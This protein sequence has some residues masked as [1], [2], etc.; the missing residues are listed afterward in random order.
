MDRRVQAVN[1]RL[2]Q[3]IQ[4]VEQR[5]HDR[6]GATQYGIRQ[7]GDQLLEHLI[8]R[9]CC[10]LRGEIVQ[11]IEGIADDIG[12]PLGRLDQDVDRVGIRRGWSCRG[13]S[14]GRGAMDV[15]LKVVAQ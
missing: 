1:S 10:K 7:N 11:L 12:L 3:V 15:A 14:G 4:D 6:F 8:K 5:I 2:G 9:Q 13:G